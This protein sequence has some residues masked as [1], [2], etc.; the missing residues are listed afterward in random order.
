MIKLFVKNTPE[1][2]TWI[3]FHKSMLFGQDSLQGDITD[4]TVLRNL[5]CEK[6]NSYSKSMGIRAVLQSDTNLLKTQIQKKGFDQKL[7]KYLLEPDDTYLQNVVQKQT[8]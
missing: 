7:V 8:L 1:V 4:N 3:G 6:T 5:L 2:N